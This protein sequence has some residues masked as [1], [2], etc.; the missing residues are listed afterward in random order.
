LLL[1]LLRLLNLA[2]RNHINFSMNL[3]KAAAEQ[4]TGHRILSR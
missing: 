1:L 2:F 3:M 4:D